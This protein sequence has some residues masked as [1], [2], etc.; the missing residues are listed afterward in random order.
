MRSEET[1]PAFIPV[2]SLCLAT[3][4]RE[5]FVVVFLARSAIWHKQFLPWCLETAR[6]LTKPSMGLQHY[7]LEAECSKAWI[8]MTQVFFSTC[9]SAPWRYSQKGCCLFYS[10]YC[11]G[12]RYACHRV[13]RALSNP[14]F[15]LQGWNQ[16]HSQTDLLSW[17]WM[18]I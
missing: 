8:W 12:Q 16:Y 15:L 7:C 10:K 14:M 5:G 4:K 1:H 17:V 18:M 3:E 9:F 2:I 6:P 11:L 13:D